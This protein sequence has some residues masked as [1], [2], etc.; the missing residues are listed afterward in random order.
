[1][2]DRWAVGFRGDGPNPTNIWLYSHWGGGSRHETL[3]A[4]IDAARPRWDDNTYAT[5]IAVSH[6][7]G[8]DWDRETGYGLEAGDNC[9]TDVEYPLMLVDWDKR[10]ISIV[11]PSGLVVE[12]ATLDAYLRSV[13]ALTPL[14]GLTEMPGVL[15]GEL[16]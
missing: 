11:A 8:T 10:T 13:A 14:E 2:G 16:A 7:I 3:A 15:S 12:T 4:A 6:I 9:R 1:V 5:R